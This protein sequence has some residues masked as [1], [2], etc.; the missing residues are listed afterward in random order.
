MPILDNIFTVFMYLFPVLF[1]F[2]GVVI[3]VQ[4]M[5]R[6][7]RLIKALNMSLLL[8]TMPKDSQKDEKTE[9]IKDLIGQIEQLYSILG[10]IGAK[11]S[12]ESFFSG[13]SYLGLEIASIGKEINFYIAA[14]KHWQE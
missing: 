10:S 9:N 12:S 3:F 11:D 14:P 4:I 13:P 8:V 6:R 2:L 5:Q 7:G 1:I